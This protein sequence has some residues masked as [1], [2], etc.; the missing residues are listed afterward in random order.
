MK[1]KISVQLIKMMPCLNH[2]HPLH[3]YM[4]DTKTLLNHLSQYPELLE[5]SDFDFLKSFFNHHCNALQSISYENPIGNEH[6]IESQ[7]LPS[8][9][10]DTNDRISDKNDIKT[11]EHHLKQNMEEYNESSIEYWKNDNNPYC[12]QYPKQLSHIPTLN[13]ID[14]PSLHT[15][16]LK[17]NDLGIDCQ[18]YDVVIVGAGAA[19]IGIAIALLAG[20]MKRSNML[21]LERDSVGSSFSNWSPFTRFISPSFHSNSFGQIDLNSTD[22]FSSVASILASLPKSNPIWLDSLSKT[23]SFF[24]NEE[25]VTGK[26]YAEYLKINASKWNIPILEGFNVL[27][28]V[29]VPPTQQWNQDAFEIHVQHVKKKELN[30]IFSRFVIWC[31]GEWSYPKYPDFDKDFI[32]TKTDLEHPMSVSIVNQKHNSSQ[33]KAFIHYAHLGSNKQKWKDFLLQA[34]ITNGDNQQKTMKMIIVGAFEAG[35]DTAYSLLK[36]DDN[37]HIT[38]VESSEDI[39][40]LMGILQDHRNS[41]P[42]P[43]IK[44]PIKQKN[45]DPSLN[46]SSS[47]IYRLQESLNSGRLGLLLKATCIGT[48]MPQKHEYVAHILIK[49]NKKIQN[50][51]SSFPIILCT[52]FDPCRGIMSKLFCMQ[53]CHDDNLANSTR[54]DQKRMDEICDFKSPAYVPFV[55]KECDESLKTSRVFLCGPMLRHFVKQNYSESKT[56][57]PNWLIDLSANRSS[58]EKKENEII[59]CFIYKFRS[60]FALVASEILSRLILEDHLDQYDNNISGNKS[61]LSDRIFD[62][63]G[64][65]RIARMENMINI[66]KEKGLFSADLNCCLC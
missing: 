22:P 33:P 52:G 54:Q 55:S 24:Y 17:T 53:K 3:K 58:I 34:Y 62:E 14:D 66:Y 46:L 21:I 35:I 42:T 50:I 1:K 25:H 48:S 13:N 8:K 44:R 65:A 28:I 4:N 56:C 41:N 64:H 5:N 18:S 30:T 63:L 12:Y 38:L 27:D 20:G 29:K 15:S 51:K 60:R 37:I 6:H 9:D 49:E 23:N 47:A 7:N 57:L 2:D 59:F 45:V 19:G 32:S 26:M 43:S 11:P 31:G 36:L 10:D 40:A 39:S 61:I 16:T